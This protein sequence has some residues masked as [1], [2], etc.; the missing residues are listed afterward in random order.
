M[1]IRSRVWAFGL[2]LAAS[3]PV[4]FP[5]L[6][7]VKPAQAAAKKPSVAL[8]SIEGKRAKAVRGWVIGALKQNFEVT[9]AEEVVP[10]TGNDAAFAKSGK[11]LGSDWVMTGKVEANK[12]VLTLRS[13]AD[14]AVADTIEVKGAGWKL[15]RAVGKELPTS[16]AESIAAAGEEEEEEEEEAPK[17]TPAKAAKAAEGEEEEEEEDEEEEEAVEGG[18]EAEAVEEEAEEPAEEPADSGSTATSVPLVLMGGLEAMRRDFTY[19]DQ[20]H[21]YYPNC[22]RCQL[23][24]Y[25]LPLQ[26]GA[27]VKLELYPA[28][29]FSGGFVSNI[30][31]TFEFHQGL[32]TKS[33]Y[34]QDGKEEEF[35]NLSQQWAAGLRFRFPFETAEVGAVAQYG[36]HKFFLKGDENQPIVPD[37]KYGFVKLGAEA[38]FRLGKVTLGAK[39]GVRL[40]SS[41]GEL[42]TLWFP[43]ATGTGL[44][45]GIFGGYSLSDSL[46]V[47]ASIDA[48]RYGFDFNAIPKD[49]RVAAG[50]AIDQYF[51]GSLGVR[52]Q[53]GGGSTTAAASEPAAEAEVEAEVEAEAEAEAE[54]DS[55]AEE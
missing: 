32:T 2:V 44:D 43:G 1:K 16:L 3:T 35:E 34:V 8:G 21:D 40:L 20:I 13:S 55:E 10:K 33:S 42:E 27:F 53:L 39:L 49:N 36:I 29:F 46:A 38:A 25:H 15:K 52:F 31:L 24:D 22:D 28:A 54:D 6:D 50:G 41:L 18:A 19:K 12:L 17:A 47:V 9:D 11:T 37:V 30:G 4:A 26:P 48:L 5:S 45:A 14:G 51:I 7:L 23:S